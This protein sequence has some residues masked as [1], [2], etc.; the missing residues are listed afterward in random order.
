MVDNGY[1]LLDLELLM[2]VIL[3]ITSSNNNN[4]ISLRFTAV[5]NTIKGY[6]MSRLLLNW[7]FFTTSA[8]ALGLTLLV[9]AKGNV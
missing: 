4:R 7:S 9:K 8:D 3:C 5:H 1:I 2:I 6:I